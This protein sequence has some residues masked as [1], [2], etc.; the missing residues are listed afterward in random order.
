MPQHSAVIEVGSFV[1]I[2]D[3]QHPRY[4]SIPVYGKVGNLSGETAQVILP[5]GLGLGHLTER[6]VSQLELTD[7]NKIPLGQLEELGVNLASVCPE[8]FG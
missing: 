5:H 2:P 4:S 7:R 3:L 1:R 6:P 8:V